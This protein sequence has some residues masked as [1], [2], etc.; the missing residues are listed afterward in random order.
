MTLSK[1]VKEIIGYVIIAFIIAL[2]IYRLFINAGIPSDKSAFS[3]SLM[4][5]AT[6]V[7]LPQIKKLL[8]NN[9]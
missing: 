2:F 7:F 3:A 8:E 1:K 5:I 9:Y 6:L 4:F